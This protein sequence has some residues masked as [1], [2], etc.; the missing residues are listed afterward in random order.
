MRAHALILA[1]CVAHALAA[2]QTLP[3]VTFSVMIS[4]NNKNPSKPGL[5]QA[6]TSIAGEGAHSSCATA[7]STGVHFPK[8]ACLQ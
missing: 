3:K 1:A 7:A 2:L 6:I 4:A 5:R 8:G